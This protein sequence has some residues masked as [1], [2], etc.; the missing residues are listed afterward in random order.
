MSVRFQN[1]RHVY[2]TIDCA[3]YIN[4]NESSTFRELFG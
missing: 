1:F 4:G 2:L 3:M